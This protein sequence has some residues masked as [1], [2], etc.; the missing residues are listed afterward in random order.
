MVRLSSCAM[1]KEEV[2]KAVGAGTTDAGKVKCLYV[3][4]DL[5]LVKWPGGSYWSGWSGNSYC[6]PWVSRYDMHETVCYRNGKEVWNC[7]R[8]KDG[9]LTAGRLEALIAREKEALD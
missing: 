1:T 3:D 6:S 2:E 9:R 4:D 7:A 8:K 5:A